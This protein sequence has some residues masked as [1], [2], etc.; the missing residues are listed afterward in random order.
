MQ[1]Q[2]RVAI[3]CK[4]YALFCCFLGRG[5]SQVTGLNLPSDCHKV[6][7]SARRCK[8]YSSSATQFSMRQETILS[9]YETNN[10]ETLISSNGAFTPILRPASELPIAARNLSMMLIILVICNNRGVRTVS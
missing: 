6:T 5:G 4:P 1:S 8:R 7:D 10:S 9:L 3:R 2:S